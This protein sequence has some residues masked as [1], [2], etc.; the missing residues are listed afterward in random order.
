MPIVEETP[1]KPSRTA[2]SS[3]LKHDLSVQQ[4]EQVESPKEPPAKG[5]V[6][7]LAA[8]EE[9]STITKQ[10]SD[11]SDTKEKLPASPTLTKPGPSG[12]QPALKGQATVKTS[13][14]SASPVTPSKPD[15]SKSDSTKRK[16]PGKLDI[17]AAISKQKEQPPITAAT[18]TTATPVDIATPGR[19][20][21]APSQTPSLSKLPESPSVGS[22]AVKAAPRTIRLT[23]TPKAETPSAKE[24]PLPSVPP[25]AAAHKFPSR[26]P[27]V[28]SIN[29]PGT[30][31]SEQ[32]SI[33]DNISM[34]STSQSRANSP[35][36]AASKVGSAPVRTKTKNQLKKERQERAKALEEEKVKTEEVVKPSVEEPAQEAIVSRK[37]KTKKETQPKPAKAKTPGSADPTPTASRSA[38]PGKQPVAEV[39][40]IKPEAPI[41]TPKESK[42]AT[43]T[44]STPTPQQ[45]PSHTPPPQEPSPPPTPTL[46][47]AQLVNELKASAPEIQKC[48]DN[49]FRISNSHHFKQSPQNVSHK[50]LLAGWKSDF[51]LRLTKEEVDALLTG[52]VPALQRGGGE[53]DR[54]F[55]RHMVT[56]SGAHL[57]ALT[58]ELE[59]RFL[60]LEKALREM[61][62][63][64]RFRPS[65]PQNEMRLPAFDLEELRRK[66][67]NGNARGVSVMEQMVQDGSTMKKG[68]FLVDEASK[69]INEFVMPPATPPP[70]QQQQQAAQQARGQ[71]GHQQ[72][73][74]GAVAAEG[75]ATNVP[76]VE[77]AERQLN[78]ARRVADEKEN[79]LKKIIKKNKRMLG[80]S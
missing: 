20:Q 19:S 6:K 65:K 45:G 75:G 43:P 22:P 48:I 70:Q 4:D 23:Q 49:L 41:S 11:R 79:A 3:H 55:D 67:E 37:K 24:F 46:T 9:A 74:Q 39:T 34:T 73:Q 35:P 40:A 63:E 26:Q 59:S 28:A 27:S 12:I 50:D 57:R 77:I 64:H 31:S 78:E 72:A 32:V 38:S 66:F 44:R 7:P 69:Y 47:A 16:P 68:A 53:N 60:E 17:T 56:P 36:P 76:S 13:D 30:P 21:R 2:S 5:A 10:K 61:P 33:S 54:T 62:S 29:P 15:T 14:D 42:P 80:L 25:S 52:K 58:K 18:A 8:I 1:T 51:N 71:H